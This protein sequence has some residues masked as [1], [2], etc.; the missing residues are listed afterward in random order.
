MEY[1][2]SSVNESAVISWKAGAALQEVRGRAVRFDENGNVILAG[3]GDTPIGFGILSNEETIP[4]GGDVTVQI[5]AIGLVRTGSAVNCGD[6]LTTDADGALVPASAGN[7]YFA[8]ALQ[9][10]SAAGTMIQ[11]L[12]TRSIKSA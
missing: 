1:M 5:R 9:D 7:P 3:A 11:A 6:E 8:V 4:A 2:T 10:A 12:I